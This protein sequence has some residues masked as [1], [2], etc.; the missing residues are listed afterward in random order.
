MK[1]IVL[2]LFLVGF[3]LALVG[4]ETTGPQYQHTAEGTTYIA[5]D[6]IS[7][8]DRSVELQNSMGRA[9]RSQLLF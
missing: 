8:I 2:S 1:E 3:A 9:T 5:R 6:P 7:S 4:C